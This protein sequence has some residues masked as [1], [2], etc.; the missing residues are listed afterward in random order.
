MAQQA[1][2]QL[3]ALGP[4]LG[5]GAAQVDGVP[6]DDGRDRQIQARRPVA[7][8]FEGAVPDLALAMEKQRAGQR[9]AGLA[10]IEAG[11]AP[12]PQRRIGRA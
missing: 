5:H 8:V 10:F 2:G 7:L 11:V 6:E 12:A 1:I 4:Q 9:V 3:F